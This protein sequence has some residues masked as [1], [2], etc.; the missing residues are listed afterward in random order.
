VISTRW[1]TPSASWKNK[2]F[3]VTRGGEEGL[4]GLSALADRAD[5]G[6]GPPVRA[7]SRSGNMGSAGFEDA[8]EI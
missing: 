3:G 2:G 4:V 7:A 5:G 6:T 8:G 1:S